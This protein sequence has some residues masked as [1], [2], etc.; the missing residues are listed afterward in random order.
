M[1]VKIIAEAGVNHNGDKDLA[2]ALVEKAAEAGADFVK[3]QTFSAD[4]LASSTAPKADYQSRTTDQDESQ[5]DMLKKLELPHEWHFELRSLAESKGIGFLTTAFDC[6][7][8]EF[9]TTFDLPFYKIPSGE[10]TNAP[11]LW[12]FAATKK[13]LILSTGMANISEIELAL[14]IIAYSYMHDTPPTSLAD[15]WKFWSTNEA[16]DSIKD[17]VTLLHCTSQYPTPSEEVN[18]RVINT[19]RNTFMLPVGYSDHTEGLLIPVAAVA[20]GA[21]VIE[22]HF[23]LDRSL[24]GP[25]HKASITADELAVMVQQIREVDVALG[26]SRKVPQPS[27][28]GTRLAARQSLVATKEIMKGELFTCDN[29]GT[30]RAGAGTSPVNYWDYIGQPSMSDIEKGDLV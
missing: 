10:I 11:L 26:H 14:A 7:S 6:E 19:L 22:K 30:A 3:F 24:P 15:F 13:D 20:C 4:R 12:E 1:T 21:V 18:L 25:D 29:L 17:K 23:T 28:W 16:Y 27:E 9:L 8:L 2:F 5:L